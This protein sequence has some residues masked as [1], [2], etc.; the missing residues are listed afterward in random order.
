M[1]SF[2][3]T[4]GPNALHPRRMTTLERRAELC[5]I[6]ALGLIRLRLRQLSELPKSPERVRY[7]SRAT[8]AVME[9]QLSGET[10]DDAPFPNL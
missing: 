9:P 1:M 3:W 7:T 4:V 6:L 10:H 8:G 2:A 5:A